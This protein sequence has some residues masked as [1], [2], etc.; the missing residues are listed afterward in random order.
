MVLVNGYSLGLYVQSCSGKRPELAMIGQIKDEQEQ[1]DTLL[2]FQKEREG[3]CQD[4]LEG[5]TSLTDAV[6]RMARTIDAFRQQLPPYPRATLPPAPQRWSVAVYLLYH[7]RLQAGDAP[8]FHRMLSALQGELALQYPQAAGVD[9][10]LI[11]GHRPA[12]A[13]VAVHHVA[14]ATRDG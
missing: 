11:P 6:E 4:L 10:V 13:P 1:L 14:E 3:V 9:Q 2:L 7:A 5:R 12:W 8:C